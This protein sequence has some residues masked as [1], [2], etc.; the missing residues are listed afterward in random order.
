MLHIIQ[1]IFPVFTII[2]LGWI[3]RRKG[4]LPAALID[5]LNR[6]VYYFA[7]PALIF[8]KVAAA[9]FDADFDPLVLA[10][11]P[12]SGCRCATTIWEKQG[13]PVRVSWPGYPPGPFVLPAFLK[14]SRSG[15]EKAT[16][17]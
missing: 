15:S 4:F 3:L 9:S 2:L 14:T 6:L 1:T 16:S 7:I 17:G 12:I 5:P 11:L 10:T 8:R 13:S